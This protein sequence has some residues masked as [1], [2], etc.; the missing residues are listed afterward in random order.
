MHIVFD[1]ALKELGD[2]FMVLELDTFRDPNH[3][4]VRTAWCV[5]E[6][7]PLEEMC[8]ADNLRQAHQDLMKS[9]RAQ[10]WERCENAIN[11]LLGRWNRELDS[12]YEIM[13]Q[14]IDSLR[15][16]D[17]PADWDSAVPRHLPPPL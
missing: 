6:N 15:Q 12:F 1:D 7:I 14:R 10:Q 5:V 4:H 8:I 16:Q 9:Y 17:L 3:G 13:S 11:G 2:K